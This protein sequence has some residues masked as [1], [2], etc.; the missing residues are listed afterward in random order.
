MGKFGIRFFPLDLTLQIFGDRTHSLANGGTKSLGLAEKDDF[1]DFAG[2]LVI[3]DG[4]DDCEEF[5]GA[6]V[7]GNDMDDFKGCFEHF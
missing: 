3:K 5:A 2:V 6:L 1:D 7:D 4:M